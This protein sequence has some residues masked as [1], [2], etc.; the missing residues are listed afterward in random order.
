LCRPFGVKISIALFSSAVM[1]LVCV[2]GLISIVWPSIGTHSI[3]SFDDGLAGNWKGIFVHKNILGSL[4]AIA[5]MA[6][7]TNGKRWTIAKTL[8]TGFAVIVLWQSQSKTSIFIFLILISVL[9]FTSYNWISLHRLYLVSLVVC[10]ILS[11][12][13]GFLAY[14][15]YLG[16]LDSK[17]FTGRM[18]IW[19]AV[20]KLSSDSQLTG[21][22]YQSVFA[23]NTD[24]AW[25]NVLKLT[26][27]INGD[28]PHLH[29]GYLDVLV[30]TG[31]IGFLLFW[32]FVFRN[33]TRGLSRHSEQ[34][35]IQI[36]LSCLLS[37]FVFLQSAT[38]VTFLNSHRIG[39]I[40]LV[41]IVALQRVADTRRIGTS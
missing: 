32:N 8:L 5:A 2:S 34:D 4:A 30:S 22:G 1:L 6:S 36:N 38:E 7:I 9:V 12:L 40:V 23:Q 29:N 10:C 20:V 27:Q 18:R 17:L 24:K 14:L 41:F 28:I 35:Q 16:E 25:S 19:E 37:L 33:L 13:F 15:G 31:W 39:W 21:L 3:S 11:V 26:S